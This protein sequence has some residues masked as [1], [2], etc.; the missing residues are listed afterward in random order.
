MGKCD[1]NTNA[2]LPHTVPDAVVFLIV[3]MRPTA[4][5][6]LLRLADEM[7]VRLE[8]AKGFV[9]GL[10]VRATLGLWGENPELLAALPPIVRHPDDASSYLLVEC[11]RWL[12]AE[13]ANAEP[14]AAPRHGA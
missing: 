4:R 1:T 8:V 10:S 14:G 7:D 9:T 6:A 13:A 3:R 12:R 5:E 2:P 11:W